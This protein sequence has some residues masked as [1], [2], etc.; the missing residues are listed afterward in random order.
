MW[1]EICLVEYTCRVK[2][3]TKKRW[4]STLLFQN[5]FLQKALKPLKKANGIDATYF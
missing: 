1:Y 2:A 3:D 4:S 5:R